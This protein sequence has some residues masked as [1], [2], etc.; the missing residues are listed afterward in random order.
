MTD[1]PLLVGAT[2]VYPWSDA[3]AKQFTIT[4]KFES[5]PVRLWTSAQNGELIRLPRAFCPSPTPETDKRVWGVRQPLTTN[6]VPRNA[7]QGD[8]IDEF[9]QLALAGESFRLKAPTGKGKTVIAIAA[10]ARIGVQT[11]IV[12]PKEDLFDMWLSEL[13]KFGIPLSD[14]GM[15]RQDKYAVANKRVVVAMLHSLA[16]PG[17]YPAW[18]AKWPGMTIYDECHRLPT[19]TFTAVCAMFSSKV[20]VGLSATHLRSD[21]LDTV[22]DGHIGPIRIEI[23][24]EDMIPKVLI[25]KTNWECPRRY[26]S[27]PVTGGKKLIRVPHAPGKTM[28][29]VVQ[30]AKDQARNHLIGEDIMAAYAKGRQI[31]FFSDVIDHLDR[32]QMVLKTLGMPLKDM[33]YYVGGMLKEERDQ[34]AK[35]P[36]LLGTWSMFA[37]GTNIETLD[38]AVLGTPRS[39]VNQ[40]VGRIRRQHP[41]KKFPAV[42]DYRDDD[43]HVFK[44]YADKREWWYRQLGCEIVRMN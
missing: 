31:V 6:I 13:V 9:V 29:I 5:E 35:R 17:K 28:H 16:I 15:V 23:S 14:I 41:T 43:S 30:M 22:V 8:A 4:S 21:G 7:D 2:A 18:F 24:A 25:K 44:A 38:T 42:L 26:V 27:D 12:V 32:M 34:S 39:N 1:P 40:P 11:L 33:A 10:L 37:E 20:R 19:E 3:L 36:L